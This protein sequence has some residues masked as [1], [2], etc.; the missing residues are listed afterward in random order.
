VKVEHLEIV[1]GI[2]LNLQGPEGSEAYY[3]LV[4]DEVGSLVYNAESGMCECVNLANPEEDVPQ[5]IAK[6]FKHGDRKEWLDAILK[7]Y[8]NLISKGTWRVALLPKGRRMLGC[9]LVLKRKVDKHGNMASYKGQCVI[10]GHTQR[11]GVDYG[12]LF[13]PVVALS[14]L[15]NQCCFADHKI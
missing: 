13:Q 11:E 12:R 2:D 4:N 15:R 10:Q 1:T 8:M 14:T 7:E 9:R 5:N 3:A 6:V